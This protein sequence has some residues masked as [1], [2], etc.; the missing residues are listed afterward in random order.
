MSSTD[1]VLSLFELVIMVFSLCLHDCVQAWTANRLGDPTA[2]MMGRL[3]MNPV[4]HYDPLGTILFPIIYLFRSPPFLLGWSKPVPL[5]SR[6]FRKPRRDE[7]LVYSS[8]P[9]AQISLAVVSL[10]AIIILRHTS[11]GAEPALQVASHLA[12][13]FQGITVDGLP[14]LTPV[15][16]LLYY[17]VFLNTLLFSFNLIPF[18]FFDGGKILANQLPYNLSQ[19]Y[20]NASMFFMFAFFFVGFPLVMISFAPVMAIFDAIMG[21]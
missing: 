12:R 7:N 21:V 1:L 8:G 3:T 9:I 15:M 5:T 4:Q 13:H 17:T 16:L 6:N 10:I 2:R 19:K 11:A 14:P 20:Q 18:P